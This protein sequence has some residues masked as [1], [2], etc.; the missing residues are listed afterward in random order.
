MNNLIN[1]KLIASI[2][3]TKFSFFILI[4]LAYHTLPFSDGSLRANFSYSNETITFLT[5]FKTWDGQHY[6]A[7]SESGYLANHMSSAFYP[8]YPILISLTAPILND[9]AVL[10]G[11]VISNVASLIAYALLFAFFRKESDEE[12]ALWGTLIMLSFPVAFYTNILYSEAIFLLLAASLFWSAANKHWLILF[13]SALLLPLTRPQG[14]MLALPFAIYVWHSFN[15]KLKASLF[16][17]FAITGIFFALGFG[18]YLSILH[19]ETG[20]ALSG[21]SA[22][23]HFISGNSLSNLAHP[24][25]WF[26]RNFIDNDLSIHGFTNSWLDRLFFI[27]LFFI[28]IYYRY[29]TKK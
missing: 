13:L 28:V 25:E 5:A 16:S 12:T 21:F 6:H 10:A 9:N 23:Q 20:N 8:L 29:E 18:L 22:Q 4:V 17:P 27:F 26:K 7:I 15:W 24:T 14:L 1:S 2:L 11:I 3:V 19:W